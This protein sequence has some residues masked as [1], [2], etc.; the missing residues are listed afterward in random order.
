LSL[1]GK[2][3]F[4]F[5]YPFYEST[6]RRRKT[7]E[8]YRYLKDTQ[9][10]GRDELLEI[11]FR[12]LK[13]LLQHAY[14][15][16]PFY[17]NYYRESG[18]TPEDI[19]NPDDISK[20]PVIDKDVIR[21]NKDQMVA[22]NMR[23]QTIPKSTGGSTGQPLEFEYT[24]ASYE[25]RVATRLRGYGWAGCHE[26]EKVGY[27]WG[28][29]VGN[30]PLKQRA[31][32]WFHHL[33][34][35]QKYFNTFVLD[36]KV[37]ADACRQLKRYSPDVLVAYTT[38]MYNFAVSVRDQGIE[39]PRVR[40]VITA[41]EKVQ[42]FQ[43]ET[44]EEVFG[45]KVFNTYG[46]REFMLIA[47]ECEEHSGLHVNVENLYV[48]ID[49]D[50]KKLDP[51]GPGELLVT[52]L[53][54]FGMPFIRYNIGDLGVPWMDGGCACGRGLPL[55][56][57]VEGRLLDTIVTPAGRMVPGEFF[58]HLAKEFKEIKQFQ[59]VQDELERLVIKVV[60]SFEFTGA[61]LEQFK[62]EIIGVIGNEIELDIQMVDEIPLTA[63]GKYRVAIS[64]VWNAKR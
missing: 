44:I 36:D 14:D 10:L 27:I 26:G 41:A 17:R 56:A 34:L 38:P 19:V 18:I 22:R 3:Y 60:P 15:Q 21:A 23:G 46:S 64:N 6:F 33:L 11:Q 37:I 40:S 61:P 49:H 24:R 25:W 42:D 32:E 20:L 29:A 30:P 58:P 4:S 8:H 45:C 52:D 59:V 35:R 12:G 7:F 53:H 1:Y 43:R 28:A 63:T 47:S 39:P 54:N 31:K 57:D 55:I 13:K 62:S 16:V 5:L 50:S 51:S 48:E 2:F 9:W